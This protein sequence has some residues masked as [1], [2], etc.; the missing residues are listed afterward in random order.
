MLINRVE[1]Y[2]LYFLLYSSTFCMTV[3]EYLFF[4]LQSS[5]GTKRES[6]SSTLSMR[7]YYNLENFNRKLLPLKIF[8]YFPYYNNVTFI[9]SFQVHGI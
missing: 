4:S 5:H 6:I 7:R 3:C 9:F 2:F 1:I 8:L